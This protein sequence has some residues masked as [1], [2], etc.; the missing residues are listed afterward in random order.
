MSIPDKLKSRKFILAV[1]T[2]LLIIANEGLNLNIPEDA[3]LKI[4]QLV[5]AYIGIE[6]VADTVSRIKK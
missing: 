1:V 2:A 4:V 3:V 5:I 6:G